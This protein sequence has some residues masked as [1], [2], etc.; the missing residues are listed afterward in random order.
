V[1]GGLETQGAEPTD[2]GSQGVKL[3]LV[4][5]PLLP[6]LIFKHEKLQYECLHDVACYAQPGD[7]ATCTD[8]KSGFHHLALHPSMWE[9]LGFQWAG[10]CYAFTHMPFGVG[11]APWTY[12]VVKQFLMRVLRVAGGIRI[13]AYIDDQLALACTAELA[14]FQQYCMLRL[15]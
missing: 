2:G 5:H 10:K 9:L 12:T 1:Q 6:N 14:M 3:R 11:P 8:E 15:Q 4:I 13:T 7:F